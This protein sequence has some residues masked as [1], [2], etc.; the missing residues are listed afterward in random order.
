MKILAIHADFIEFE[1]KKKAMKT[2]EEGVKEEKQRVEECL[3]VFTAVE[4]AD[5]SNA[6]Q[7]VK[8]YVAQVE[9]IAGQV[10]T[11]TIVLYPYAHLSPSLSKP[12]VAEQVMKDAEQILSKNYKVSR[13]PFGW[14]KSFNISCKGH[15]LS[16]LSRS[17][18][19]SSEEEVVSAALKAEETLKS[20]WFILDLDGELK[21]IDKFDYKNYPV[22]K[23][24]ASYEKNKVRVAEK[25][26]PHIPLMKKLELVD[27][28]PA[29]DGG[30]FRYYPKGRL[31]KKLIEEFVTD[32]VVDYGGLEVE[33]PIMYD[34][35]HPT[36][37]K[38][39]NKFP[40]RQ[41][42]IAS[43][44]RTFFLRFAACF[45]QF[46]IA[47]DSTLSYRNLP[48]KLYEMTRYSFRREQ[49]GELSGLRRLR[50]FTMP[51]VHA[52]CQDIDQAKDEFMNRFHLCLNTVK[53]FDFGPE[54]LELAIRVTKTFYEENKELIHNLVKTYGKPALLEMWDE[55]KFYFLLKYEFNYVDNLDKASALSTDQIDVMNGI[56][57]DIK[58]TGP[59][60]N[61]HHPIILHCSPSGAVE[62]VVYA[63]LERAAKEQKEGRAATLPLWLCP[64][65]VRVIP[66]SPDKHLQYCDKLADELI[67]NKIRADVDDNTESIGKRVRNAEKEWAPL[68]VV[69]GDDEMSSGKLKVRIRGQKDIL[70]FSKEDFIKYIKEKIEGK[71]WKKL[72]LPKH[73]SKRAIFVG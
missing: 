48:L 18:S 6:K 69:I 35:K 52:L 31:M 58:F 5:E 17:F 1:P 68:I 28:E 63:L 2:A 8:Q 25:E 3:V 45:G 32:T 72:P 46:L 56:D 13:A 23:K 20:N 11:D 40:A 7:A 50:A 54:N 27:Y 9:D 57:Y 42:Q 60:G 14:Y 53:G 12:K 71:P 26:P 15:P 49:S 55:Q 16:E 66:V 70:E 65:Q 62:R 67:T 43:D 19:P 64:T 34:I 21:P 33:T 47:H 38:Y 41:Y 30:N 24:F 37:E 51:D 61:R 39:L 22:L 73:L 4:E 29:S 44:K 36:L 10:K 59:D